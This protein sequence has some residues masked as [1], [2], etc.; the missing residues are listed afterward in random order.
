[1]FAP[2]ACGI[3]DTDPTNPAMRAVFIL[4]FPGFQILDAAGPLAA[5]EIA[6]RHVPGSYVLRTVAAESGLVRSSSGA[7]LQAAALP[8]ATAVDTLLVAG[9]DGC[10]A[11]A[12]CARTRRC[13]RN[14]ARTARRVASVCSG[15]YVLAAAGVL[16]GLPA[17]THW[18]RARDFAQRF[19]RVRLDADK[20]FIR[21]GNI[22]TSAGISAGIDL[23]LAMIA[24]DLGDAVARRT[25]Q[26]LV[27]YYRRPGGQSQ[28]SALLAMDQPSGR[29]SALLEH[30]RANLRERLDVE[31]LARRSHL[32]PRHF[33]RLFRAEVGWTPAHAVEMLRVEA[34]RARLESGAPSIQ[35]VAQECGFGS[36]ERMRRSFLRVAG[37]PPASFAHPARRQRAQG[38]A[39]ERRPIP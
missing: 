17:T 32:S 18:G 33:S 11:A 9:G 34:A 28:F 36:A 19:P 8:G 35:R 13:V 14:A 22:W 10:E 37:A 4:I 15:A 5:F 38:A 30:A 16:D 24:E 21:A 1:M 39:P 26:Q 6:E 23:A 7:C 27:V 12:A 25:A 2:Y 29:F 31:E 20:I 3:K